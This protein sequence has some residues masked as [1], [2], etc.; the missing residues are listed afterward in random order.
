M[1]ACSPDPHGSATYGKRASPSVLPSL[2][3]ALERDLHLRALTS[4]RQA[5]TSNNNQKREREREKNC[6]GR[7]SPRAFVS[8]SLIS[9]VQQRIDVERGHLNGG[10]LGVMRGKKER[11]Q[12]TP[13]KETERK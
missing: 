7:Q 8:L 6:Q 2:P 4:P 11:R 3:I 9:V 1:H 10:S 12:A 5:S 13:V